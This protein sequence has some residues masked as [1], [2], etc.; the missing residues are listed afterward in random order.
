MP[1][2]PSRS[3]VDVM[4]MRDIGPSWDADAKKVP[5]RKYAPPGSRLPSELPIIGLG[6]S[7]FST[8]FASGDEGLTVDNMSRGHSVVQG[9]VETIRHAILD[10]GITLLDTAPWYGHGTSEVCLG[11]L[12]FLASP[13]LTKQNFR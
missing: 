7:S 9:W 3:C 11:E 4:S 5:R 10:R 13:S 12:P 1:G 6:C 2:D 8:F